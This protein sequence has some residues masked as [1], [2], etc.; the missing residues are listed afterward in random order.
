MFGWFK[1]ENR[2]VVMAD[3]RVSDATGMVQILGLDGFSAGET[4][5]VDSALGVPA[6]SAAVNF[7]SRSLASLP[8]HVYRKDGDGQKR[9]TDGVEPLLNEAPN[10]GTSAFDW[11]KYFFDQ[12]FTGG[13]GLSFLERNGRGQVIAIW[14]LDPTQATIERV[15]GRKFY[16]YQD[17]G[18][19]VRYDAGEVI[20]LAFMLKPDGLTHRSPLM[21]CGETISMAIAATKFGASYFRGG[22]IPPYAVTGNFQS[23]AAMTRAATDLEAA[24][25]KAV[26]EKR[27]ALMLPQGL[28]IQQIGTD[29]E[30]AQFI[31]TQRFL[32]EQIARIF[33]L[34]PV[35][36]QDLT[37]GTF[38]NT[39]QQDL[40]LVKHTLR[41]W[42]QQFED[43]LNLKLFGW[44]RRSVWVKHNL[45]GLLRG[46]FKTRMDG[47]SSAI[48][49]GVLTPGEARELEDRP[50]MDGDDRL[51]MQGAMLPIDKLGADAPVDDTVSEMMRGLQSQ[52]A[53]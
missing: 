12:V 10:E 47:Y 9:A 25:S 32:V 23:G 37:H 38:S 44:K 35:F 52:V 42:V 29:A 28:T 15:E 18:R 3:V 45:D 17:G 16:R 36:L 41:H 14:P 51:Y 4:V 31:E 34:P 19:T 20:D 39:E 43:E 49:H 27:Q 50:K 8:L 33:G 53:Q 30:R 1:R 6:V 21:M 26:K 48:Q 7:Y 24:V 22:G 2:S 40:H 5:T 46:D 11:R 13:R